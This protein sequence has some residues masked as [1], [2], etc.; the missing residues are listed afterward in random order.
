MQ[1]TAP[2]SRA[3]QTLSLQRRATGRKPVAQNLI[4]GDGE[5][6]EVDRRLFAMLG[7]PRG[8]QDACPVDAG[9]DELGEPR[10]AGWGCP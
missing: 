9:G 3:E 4:R 7:Q 6:G 8:R 10:P 5:G 1:H 2:Q